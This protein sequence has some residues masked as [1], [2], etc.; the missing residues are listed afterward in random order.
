M[1]KGRERVYNYVM[2]DSTEREEQV[3]P[4]DAKKIRGFLD[5]VIGTSESDSNVR[6]VE[7]RMEEPVAGVENWSQVQIIGRLGQP[8]SSFR[9]VRYENGIRDDLVPER[10]CEYGCEAVAE[11][12]KLETVVQKGK[13]ENGP[14][15]ELVWERRSGLE[16]QEDWILAELEV[17]GIN[18]LSGEPRE[19]R[20]KPFRYINTFKGQH[21]HKDWIESFD[22]WDTQAREW[23]DPVDGEDKLLK[24]LVCNQGMTEITSSSFGRMVSLRMNRHCFEIRKIPQKSGDRSRPN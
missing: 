7:N 12:G 19:L 14:M 4:R 24:L 13:L 21:N 22:V 6:Y 15:V 2:G 11:G 18:P 16:G 10:G 1:G 3:S 9:L 20:I 5:G 17:K 23:R 8:D